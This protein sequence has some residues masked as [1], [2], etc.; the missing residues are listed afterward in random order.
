MTKTKT[1]ERI[2]SLFLIIVF[3]V[4]FSFELS[5]NQK[6]KAEDSIVPIIINEIAP[7]E[8]RDWIEFYVQQS[9]DYS[10]YKIKEGATSTPTLLIT[11]PNNFYLQEGDFIVLHFEKEIS[12]IDETTNKGE[13]DIWDLYT[14]DPDLQATDNVGIIEDKNGQII[15][16]MCYA[17]QSGSWTGSK[18]AFDA[19]I[20][21]GK[22][23][24]EKD[25]PESSCFNWSNGKNLTSLPKGESIGRDENFTDTDSADDWYLYDTQTPGQINLSEITE[26]PYSN[27]VIINELYPNPQGDDATGEF[28][29]LKNIGGGPV[30]L[31]DWELRDQST[32][33]KIKTADFSSTQ[34]P[35]GGFFVIYRPTSK[36]ALNNTGGETVSL[37]SPDGNI[38]FSISYTQTAPEGQSFALISSGWS[39]T[40][41]PTP[42][43][44][45]ILTVPP[46]QNQNPKA[47]AGDDKKIYLG[48]KVTFD[49]SSSYD[50]DNDPLSYF[51]NFG[52][53]SSASGAV[54]THSY[55]KTG[56]YKAT[57]KVEDG[58][59]GTSEDSL[60]ASV[61][62]KKQ[63]TTKKEETKKPKGPFSREVIIS[64]VMPNPQGSDSGDGRIKSGEWIELKNTGKKTVDLYY[65]QLDDIPDGGSRPYTFKEKTKIKP[66]QFLVFY[67]PQIKITLNNS[68]DMVRLLDPDKKVVSQVKYPSAKEGFAFALDP[69]TKKW[70]WT[71]KPTPGKENQIV[72]P[73]EET[74]SSK[75]TGYTSSS[76]TEVKTEETEDFNL[77]KIISIAQAREQ[78]KNTKVKVKGQVTVEPGKLGAKVFYLQ[79]ETA[80]IQ[81]YFS[82]EDFPQL[83]LG[84]L[85]TVT[86]KVSE[87]QDEKKINI[88]QKEDIAFLSHGEEPKA[89]FLK[90]GQISEEHEGRLVETE[91]EITKKVGTTFYLDDGSGT[92]RFY[93][94]KETGVKKEGIKK[95]EKVK[96]KGIVSQTTSGYRILPR[97]ENDVLVGETEI[98]AVGENGGILS[99]KKLPSVGNDFLVMVLLALTLT[100]SIF[101]PK[102]V[103]SARKV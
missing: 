103:F 9:G 38:K 64:E 49:G 70:F 36:I 35:P 4:S 8:T 72:E 94:K 23:Q 52:D 2:F 69:K 27:Q 79:D 41:T 37:L 97:Y 5:K 66:G 57:L 60:Y 48:E 42:G 44:E 96:V 16:G 39:W 77:L 17:N 55:K 86:G 58:R 20:D 102:V 26:E 7:S 88:S 93:F 65:W 50:P 54:V 40:Q 75:K 18:S 59:G 99:N 74:K 62:E 21:A 31:K 43:Q 78:E 89:I 30:D 47:I 6:S 56:K 82:K 61:L 83:N 67:Y 53:G 100:I 3:L 63:T 10:G 45:N 29:E 13:N 71:E 15:D 92:I 91:G 28:I 51:W 24:G 98:A 84:D 22:W 46:P 25:Q 19:L 87:A 11:F 32:T 14:I 1:K 76:K 73:K 81:I 101:L 80:G 33:Y 68:Q 34:I 90:T 85:I 12:E 95:G